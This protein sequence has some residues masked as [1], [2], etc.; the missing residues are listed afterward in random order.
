MRQSEE[1]L[2]AIGDN[3]PDSIIY[4]FTRDAAGNPKYLYISAG[5]ER[6]LA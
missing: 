3:L 1:M 4:R 6:L 5:V 2:R